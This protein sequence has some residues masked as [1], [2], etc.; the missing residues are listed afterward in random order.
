M[1]LTELSVE[2]R[3]R[4]VSRESVEGP[5]E[6]WPPSFLNRRNLEP[7][8]LFLELAELSNQGGDQESYGHSDRAPEFLCGDRAPEFL[9]GD[10]CPSG[11][12]SHLCSTPP[13]RLLW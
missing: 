10:G 13:I 12:F 3:N 11:R 9:C 4:I 6:Q 8:R 5:Q 1:R 2:L 7:P